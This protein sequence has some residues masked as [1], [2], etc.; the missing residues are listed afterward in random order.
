MASR[1]LCEPLLCE[2]MKEQAIFLASRGFQHHAKAPILPITRPITPGQPSLAGQ[3]L[4]GRQ[5]CIEKT[6]KESHRGNLSSGEVSQDHERRLDVLEE[7][8]RKLTWSPSPTNEQQQVQKSEHS[9]RHSPQL[10]YFLHGPPQRLEEKPNIGSLLPSRLRKFRASERKHARSEHDSG[11]FM[12]EATN[13]LRQ[14]I[15]GWK[16]NDQNFVKVRFHVHFSEEKST[17]LSLL[18]HD[19]G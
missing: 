14:Q 6:S 2:W 8:S 16:E 10:V 17:I 12:L 1:G 3:A 18:R 9:G 7:R 4:T 13:S 15:D 5:K 19:C 11:S